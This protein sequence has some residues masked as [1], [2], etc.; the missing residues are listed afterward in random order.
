LKKYQLD[1]A[2]FNGRATGRGME[3][4]LMAIAAG[5]SMVLQRPAFLPAFMEI[6]PSA[7]VG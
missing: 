5:V 2:S 3:Q 6:S 7:F 4:F 1:L